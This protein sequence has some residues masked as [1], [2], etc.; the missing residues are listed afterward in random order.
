MRV[1]KPRSEAAFNSAGKLIEYQPSRRIAIVTHPE[2]LSDAEQLTAAARQ[3]TAQLPTP[4]VRAL[5]VT[6]YGIDVAPEAHEHPDS[7]GSVLRWHVALAPWWSERPYPSLA[8]A[9]GEQD[10][11][12]SQVPWSRL[13]ELAESAR[14]EHG[15]A[16]EDLAPGSQTL[17]VGTNPETGDLEIQVSFV[18]ADDKERVIGTDFSLTGELLRN[19]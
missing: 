8:R 14:A 17:V 4:R 5:E 3:L 10:F 19:W 6:S 1:G 16:H 2:P 11:A 9:M 15:L 7:P 13:P 18:A 12:L